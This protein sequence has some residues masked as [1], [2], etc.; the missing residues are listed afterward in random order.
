MRCVIGK[1]LADRLKLRRA[2]HKLERQRMPLVV[3]DDQVPHPV[4]QHSA[5]RMS[6]LHF[7][8]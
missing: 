3:T 2:D 7:A 8:R 4:A 5:G 1:Q 6:V